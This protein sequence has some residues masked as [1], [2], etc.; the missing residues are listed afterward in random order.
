MVL[1]LEREK[2]YSRGFENVELAWQHF[3][4]KESF[5]GSLNSGSKDY[6]CAL[7]KRSVI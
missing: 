1:I 3:F 4:R 5:A 6:L 2:G 7:K